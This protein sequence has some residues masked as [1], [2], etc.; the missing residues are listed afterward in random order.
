MTSFQAAVYAVFTLFV[1]L[2]VLSFIAPQLDEVNQK[3]ASQDKTGLAND[4]LDKVN[5]IPDPKEEIKEESGG[6][7]YQ[8]LTT[9]PLGFVLLVLVVAAILVALGVSVARI[10]NL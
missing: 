9:N 10:N 3:I 7:L 4:T 6:I 1:G 8:L 2:I 5:S